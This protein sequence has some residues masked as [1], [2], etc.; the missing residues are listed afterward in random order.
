[1]NG[2]TAEGRQKMKSEQLLIMEYLFGTTHP[3][4]RIEQK[5]T[6]VQVGIV[7]RV[8]VI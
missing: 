7:I 3:I 6:V 4:H 2:L 8:F 1:M 5:D